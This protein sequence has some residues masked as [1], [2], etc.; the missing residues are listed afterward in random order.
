MPKLPDYSKGLVYKICCNDPTITEC[1][2]GSSVDYK[3]RKSSHRFHTNK[4]TSKKY[5]YPLYEKIRDNGGFE[6]WS[7][8]ILANY[9]CNDKRELELKEREHFEIEK[10]TL[11]SRIPTRSKKEYAEIHK[12]KAKHYHDDYMKQKIPCD[13]CGIEMNKGSIY[14]HKKRKH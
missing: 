5:N 8:I 12:V 6:N 3:S 14:R 11:N 2:I 4:E 10:P 9:N 13:L 1:Y 7:M